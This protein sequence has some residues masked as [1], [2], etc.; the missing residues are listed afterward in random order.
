MAT[1]MC[2][3]ISVPVIVWEKELLLED[4]GERYGNLRLANPKAERLMVLSLRRYG[5]VSPVVVCKSVKDEYELIDGF[6]RLRASRQI[7]SMTSLRAR[8]LEVGERAAKAALLCLNWTSRRVSDMEEGWVVHSL[9]RNDGLSQVEVGVL[10]GRDKSWV[11]RRLSLVERLCEE[12]QSQIRLG[13]CT[14]TMGRELARL[15]RGNQERVLEIVNRHHLVSREVSLLVSLLLESSPKRQE[16]ILCEPHKFLAG[17][18]GSPVEGVDSRLSKEGSRILRML[19][20]MEGACI[21]VADRVGIKGLNTLRPSDLLILSGPI[22]RA[23][24]ASS[25]AEQAL[26]DALTIFHEERQDA[27]PQRSRGAGASRG[28]APQGGLL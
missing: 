14:S 28:D 26:E 6:T 1:I 22:G 3:D 8:V 13:L 2:S 18:G 16:E 25:R 19:R 11:C 21:E 24:R 12:L 17:R 23:S 5:Q 27:S 9:C 4:I 15:P 7:D 20:K 10:L